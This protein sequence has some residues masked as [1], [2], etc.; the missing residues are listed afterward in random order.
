MHEPTAYA[1]KMGVPI[2]LGSDIYA[3]IGIWNNQEAAQDVLDRCMTSHKC[4]IV[5]LYE[6]CNGKD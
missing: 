2:T 6:N 3:W 5:P 1:V 4:Y